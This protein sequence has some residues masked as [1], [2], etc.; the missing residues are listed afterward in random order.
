MHKCFHLW[1]IPSRKG[2]QPKQVFFI[3]KTVFLGT[4]TPFSR[5]NMK[6]SAYLLVGIQNKNIVH[7]K[8]RFLKE[9]MFKI[10]FV[11]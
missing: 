3:K 4:I 2:H 1:V 7:I 10:Y 11:S 6:V 9:I 8:S 5:V